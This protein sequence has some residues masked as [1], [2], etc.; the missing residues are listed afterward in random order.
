MNHLIKECS[1][2]LKDFKYSYAFCGGYALELFTNTINRPHSDLDISIFSEDKRHI[3]KFMLA[4][5][6]N[7]YE[8]RT[9]WIDNKNAFSYLRSILSPNDKELLNLPAVWAMKPGCSLIKVKPKQEENIF[10]YEILSDEQLN[11]DF[12]EIIFNMQ[13]DNKFICDKDKGIMR[14]LDKA[15]SYRDGVPYLAPEILLFIIC[16]PVYINSEYHKNKNRI[17][18]NS[19]APFLPPESKEWLIN[20]LKAAYPKGNERIAELIALNK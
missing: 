7:V 8:H 17:D 20:S 5:G 18:F 11:F 19:T 13:K 2:F 3:V 6:W 12:I 15:I 10:D 4:A 9:E 14:E 1:N 16:N